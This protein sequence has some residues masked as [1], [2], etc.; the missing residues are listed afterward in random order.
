MG[1]LSGGQSYWIDGQLTG[2]RERECMKN[3]TCAAIVL[4]TLS[5]LGIK[6]NADDFFYGSTNGSSIALIDASTAT[7]LSNHE[8]INAQTDTALG[9]S[10]RIASNGTSIFGVSQNEALYSLDLSHTV[11]D[12][13]HTLGYDATL[14]SSG[15][16][17]SN[18]VGLAFTSPTLLDVSTSSSLYQYNTITHS[19]TFLF[20]FA[21][22]TQIAG[23]LM[24]I[25][26]PLSDEETR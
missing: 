14:Q 9:T 8:L 13:N 10:L 12:V 6:A 3:L 5:A 23:L 7:V 4:M 26:R 15:I 25:S 24:V 16:G 11:M 19:S 2:P 21:N 18:V 22:N 20:N 1:D 17:V